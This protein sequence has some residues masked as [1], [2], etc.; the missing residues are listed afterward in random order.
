MASRKLRREGITRSLFSS[1]LLPLISLC[2]CCHVLYLSLGMG[3]GMER[4]DG[5][6][7]TAASRAFGS[8]A[9]TLGHHP[10]VMDWLSLSVDNHMLA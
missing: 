2:D 6:G 5:E 3:I 1:A 10:A 4:W 7:C 8:S 9:P